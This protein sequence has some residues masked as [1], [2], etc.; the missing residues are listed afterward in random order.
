MN[1]KQFS[2]DTGI[3]VQGMTGKEG[4]RMTKWLLQSGM[5]VCAGVTPGKGGLIVEGCPIFNS[6]REAREAFPQIEVTSIVVP[7]ARVKGAVQEALE[8]GIHYVHILTE[9]I[10][11]H[12]VLTMRALAMAHQATILGPSSVGYLQFPAFRTGYIGGENPFAMIKEG[13]VALVSTSGGMT[14]EVMMGLARQRIGIRLAFA[15]GGDR[16]PLVSLEEAVTYCDAQTDVSHLVVFA[17]PGRS[18]FH[19][20]LQ[21][22]IA[23]I[24][25]LVV[26]LA[27]DVLDDLPRGKAYGHTGTLLGEEEMSVTALRAALQEKGIAC[28]ATMPELFHYF[29]TICQK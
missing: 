21:G 28:V 6:V 17:E 2:P 10:P 24:H 1:W 29:K 13:G 18:F 19:R 22:A 7:A 12:D 14:N 8:A 20:L 11:V 4:A 25:P 27:G 26:F 5:L 15:V 3:L 9:S 16:L 23:P